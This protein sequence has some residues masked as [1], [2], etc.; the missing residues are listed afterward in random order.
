MQM[1][2]KADFLHDYCNDLLKT[3]GTHEKSEDIVDIID[4][5]MGN[6]YGKADSD[7]LG[8]FSIGIAKKTVDR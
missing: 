4:M 1:G 3:F 2:F 5:N 7:E 8:I 6:N